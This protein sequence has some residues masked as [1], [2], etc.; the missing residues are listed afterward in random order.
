MKPLTYLEIIE[1]FGHLYFAFF[2][3]FLGSTFKYLAKRHNRRGRERLR[4]VDN[5]AMKQQRRNCPP[6][7]LLLHDSSILLQKLGTCVG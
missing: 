6:S 5:G 4:G 3:F 7:P 2:A 1:F